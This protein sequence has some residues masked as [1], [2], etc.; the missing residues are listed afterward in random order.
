MIFV[1]SPSSRAASCTT[2][3]RALLSLSTTNTRYELVFASSMTARRGTIIA[4]IVRP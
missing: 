2:R 1:L 3:R 4:L